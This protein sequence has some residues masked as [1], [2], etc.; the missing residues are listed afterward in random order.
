MKHKIIW[1]IVAICYCF[2]V[3]FALEST[4]YLVKTE[5]Y[6]I[7][8]KASTYMSEASATIVAY[9]LENNIP[10][11]D[12]LDINTTGLIGA[13]FSLLTSTSGAL[14][15][16]R[17]STNPNMA[18]VVVD[19]LLEAGVKKGDAVALN[20]SS[21][22]PAGNIAVLCAAEALALDATVI[23][24]LG[25][26]TFGGN[27]PEFAYLDMERLLYDEG[28]TS[29]RSFHFSL[30]ARNDQGGYFLGAMDDPGA[31]VDE[32]KVAK[33][34][35]RLVSYGYEFINIEESIANIDYRYDIYQ[36]TNP[37]CL[38]NVGGN[39]LAFGSNS[40]NKFVD[41]GVVTDLDVSETEH[42]LMQLFFSS[43]RPT[44]Q[45]LNFKGIATD[46]GLPI[47]PTPQPE[48]GEGDVYYTYVYHKIVILLS[49][50]PLIAV[51]VV[52]IRKKKTV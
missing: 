23:T 45:L 15:A 37:T 1:G 19:M 17:T 12:S 16:K 2:G 43:D 41:S 47:D 46:Y 38:V 44:I 13:E 7:K 20:F 33:V 32:A 4:K 40:N 10:I 8:I 21:S 25:S 6:D 51:A 50:L 22:F 31:P 29:N 52:L 36:K 39:L 27:N 35:E 42:G 14:D 49:L 48:V 9:K 3:Y 30:G 11:D 18:A 24:S 34:V 26:S 28:I 5:D